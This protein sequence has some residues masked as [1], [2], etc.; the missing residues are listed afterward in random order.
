[1]LEKFQAELSFSEEE[2]NKLYEIA[3]K[4]LC[5]EIKDKLMHPFRRQD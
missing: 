2:A 3:V 1:M 4:I 5:T